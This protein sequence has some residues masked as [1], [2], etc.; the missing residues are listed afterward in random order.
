M[1]TLDSIY[2][3]LSG[4]GQTFGWQVAD[5]QQGSEAW[6]KLKL[7]VISASRV[8]EA[9]AKKDSA[10]R[11]S[12][13]CELVAQVCTGVQEEINSKHMD[14]GNQHEDAARSCYEFMTG[15]QMTQLPFVF[16][17][18]L[19]REGC[20]PDGIV[21]N[22]RGAEIKCPW[23]SENYI[24]FLTADAI[25]PEYKWQA[26]YTM[27]IMDADAWDFVQYD[28]RMKSKPMH[29]VTFGR[30]AE[31]Q[32]KM[33]DLIPEFILDMDKMLAQ[34]GVKFGEQWVRLAKAA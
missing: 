17:D 16:K 2:Q 22:D 14:W 28:P 9:V 30:D 12:Y 3:S 27:R 26:N 6:F 8:S 4:F 1:K 34:I 21:T 29:I 31:M 25:K 19:W 13:M 18:G 10:T 20:S 33:D 5:A 7:G 24:K 11:N 23:A 15:L 32:K